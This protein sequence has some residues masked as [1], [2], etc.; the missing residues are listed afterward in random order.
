MPDYF[1]KKYDSNTISCNMIKEFLDKNN[2]ECEVRS[3]KI[4]DKDIYDYKCKIYFKDILEA[5][6]GTK[7]VEK[8]FK[9]NLDEKFSNF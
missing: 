7:I 6:R 5:V 2:I 3:E 1:Y 9:K 4:S 8:N